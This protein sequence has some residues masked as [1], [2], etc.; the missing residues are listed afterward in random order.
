MVVG[1]QCC[2]PLLCRS[3][4]IACLNVCIQTPHS[5]DESEGVVRGIAA[6]A[7]WEYESVDLENPNT[8]CHT[9]T[10]PGDSN[11]CAES[12]LYWPPATMEAELKTQLR[13]L[14]VP[15]IDPSSLM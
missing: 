1:V 7:Q 8:G 12:T 6:T 11:H 4:F 5:R 10:K 14:N 15:E 2:M 3:I 9:Y 13:L